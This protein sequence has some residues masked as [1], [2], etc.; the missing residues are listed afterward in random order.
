MVAA[1]ML[2]EV[3][4]IVDILNIVVGK[5]RRNKFSIKVSVGDKFSDDRNS[6][7]GVFDDPLEDEENS[8][9][10]CS[11]PGERLGLEFGQLCL[12]YDDV[13]MFGVLVEDGV[14]CKKR[15]IIDGDALFTV[16]WV[17]N[18]ESVL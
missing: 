2:V 18:K 8:N 15:I 9:D 10:I 6:D 11:C 4:D 1:W 12:M 13:D 3:K 14:Y 16:K 17:N 5:W 7:Y